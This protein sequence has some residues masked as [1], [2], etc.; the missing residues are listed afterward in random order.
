MA[1]IDLSTAQSH[2]NTWLAA[3]TA[4]AR[5]QSFSFGDRSLSRANLGEIRS[6]IELWDR[7]VNE[8]TQGSRVRVQQAVIYG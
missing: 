2:L 7:K 5:G 6:Q 1:G 8:L 4:V 3:E